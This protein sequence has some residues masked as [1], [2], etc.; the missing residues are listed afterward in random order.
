[1]SDRDS[2]MAGA[3]GGGP[4][5]FF[6]TL[7]DT[8]R[9]ADREKAARDKEHARLNSLFA[10]TSSSNN[11]SSATDTYSFFDFGSE[12]VDS[13]DVDFDALIENFFG[14]SDWAFS[15]IEEWANNPDRGAGI[16]LKGQLFL[17]ML[18]ALIGFL[19]AAH[20]WVGGLAGLFIGSIAIHTIYYLV[21][22]L[23]SLLL[24]ALWIAAIVCSVGLF[25]GAIIFAIDFASKF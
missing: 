23:A 6:Q 8:H 5:G 14:V 7:G 15:G 12:K 20:W 11:R 18:A 4:G 24:W 21:K 1:M 16:V 19:V 25:F 17:A 3:A 22:V 10:P 13:S 2:Y 9:Q